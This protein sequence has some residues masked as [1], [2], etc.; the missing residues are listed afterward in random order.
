MIELLSV[1]LFN[2]L[3]DKEFLQDAWS[4]GVVGSGG[5]KLPH[6]VGGLLV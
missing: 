3:I 5:T 6:D 4:M 2:T 1:D